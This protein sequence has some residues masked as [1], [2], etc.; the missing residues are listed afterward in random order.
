MRTL[1]IGEGRGS[2]AWEAG[3]SFT[4]LMP[5]GKVGSVWRVE[6]E[7]CEVW[8]GEGRRRLRMEGVLSGMPV[9]VPEEMVAVE[10][11]AVSI[12]LEEVCESDGEGWLKPLRRFGVV[13]ANPG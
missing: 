12:V 13:D 9:T 5:W 7:L 2:K 11:V 3:S 1:R 8:E 10:R 4:G 6:L